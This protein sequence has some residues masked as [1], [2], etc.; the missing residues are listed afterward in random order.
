MARPKQFVP[1]EA[2]DAAM[3]L[4]WVQGYEATSMQELVACTGVHKR[5]MYD[6]F[7]DKHALFVKALARYADAQEARLQD[8][9]EG[10]GSAIETIR[11]LLE[12]SV[13]DVT[14]QQPRGCLLV[15][16]AT[17]LGVRD[18]EAAGHVDQHFA[19]AQRVLRDLVERGRRD[20]EIATRLEP[21]ALATLLH[22]AWLGL[23]VNSAAGVP[24][25]QL[26]AGVDATIAMLVA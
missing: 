8:A 6:T 14:A 5:S 24:P 9:A 26:Q 23:R 15:N 25:S 16:S 12:T 17:E 11:A 13:P 20:G 7:G 18:P 4:F 2:L 19:L 3:R 1:D 21:A 22:N 10:T